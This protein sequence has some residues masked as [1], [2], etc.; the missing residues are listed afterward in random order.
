MDTM[1]MQGFGPE[2]KKLIQTL[3]RDRCQFL[4][5]TATLTKA[6]RR[7]LEEENYI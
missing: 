4:L 3:D 5:C 2:I 7:F 1:L 6:V